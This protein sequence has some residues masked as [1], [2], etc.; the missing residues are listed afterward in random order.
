MADKQVPALPQKTLWTTIVYSYLQMNATRFCPSALLA[1]SDPQGGRPIQELAEQV[2]RSWVRESHF[3]SALRLH[4]GSPP[5]R[6]RGYRLC[7]VWAIG[8]LGNLAF[9]A[10]DAFRFSAIAARQS[11]RGLGEAASR[12]PV[13]PLLAS[14][15]DPSPRVSMHVL[16]S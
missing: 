6:S 11:I 12:L 1:G 5:G 15:V 13:R 2:Q 10:S 14:I 3:T 4:R 9:S 16:V 7:A 8:L